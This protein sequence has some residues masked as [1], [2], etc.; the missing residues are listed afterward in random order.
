MIHKPQA[1]A[2]NDSHFAAPILLKI[3]LLGIS[4]MKYGIKK[5]RRAME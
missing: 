4:K 5:T 3:R 2:K 1:N